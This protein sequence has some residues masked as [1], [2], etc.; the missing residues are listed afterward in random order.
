MESDRNED[1]PPQRKRKISN[2]RTLGKILVDDS[3]PVV[4]VE[5]VVEASTSSDEDLQAVDLRKT[6]K[7]VPGSSKKPRLSRKAKIISKVSAKK[8]RGSTVRSSKYEKALRRRTV[9]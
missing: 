2:S 8:V 1:L 6:R 9:N 5:S 3:S 4:L 7:S